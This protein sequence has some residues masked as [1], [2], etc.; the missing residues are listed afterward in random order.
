ML[1]EEHA[2]VN[3]GCSV[4]LNNQFLPKS[5]FLPNSQFLPTKQAFR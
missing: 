4:G 2:Q 5:Q 1:R 3:S